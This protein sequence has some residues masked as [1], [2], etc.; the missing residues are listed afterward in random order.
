[1]TRTATV[2]VTAVVAATTLAACGGDSPYCAA[3]KTHQKTLG[4]FG[5]KVTDAAFAREAAAVR[6]IAATDPAKVADDW[7]AI[8]KAM[9]R[10]VTAQNK[11]GLTF[12]DL[13]DQD[14]RDDAGADDIETITQAYAS[15]NDT[16]QQRKAAVEDAQ[17]TCNVT[18]S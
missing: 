9:R 12:D 8:D 13:A 11:T 2:L 15:F 4:A 10:V 14:T 18:L 5:A 6:E 1:M 3:V 16:A 17:A 7:K